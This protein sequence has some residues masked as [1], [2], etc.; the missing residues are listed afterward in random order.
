M[1]VVETTRTLREE[2]SQ[3]LVL[4]IKKLNL[5]TARTSQSAIFDSLIVPSGSYELSFKREN[6]M[7]VIVP[8]IEFASEKIIKLPYS[9]A[10]TSSSLD[11]AMLMLKDL[12]PKLIMLA[13]MEKRVDLMS[14]E[15]EKTRRRV[16]AIEHIRLPNLEKTLK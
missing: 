15:I 5:A 3:L 14:Y 12:T 9:L 4:T 8:K 13:Q 10:Y 16:N 11:Q 2:V 1:Q 7:S 6:I